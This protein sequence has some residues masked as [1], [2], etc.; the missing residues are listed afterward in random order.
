MAYTRM[1]TKGF[2]TIDPET[3]SGSADVQFSATQNDGRNQRTQAASLSATGVDAIAINIVQAGRPEFVS[4]EASKAAVKGGETVTITGESNSAS[5]TVSLGTGN[6]EVEVP[7]TITA[8]SV[9]TDNGA[10]IAGD[11]GATAKY[12]YTFQIVVPE[13]ETIEEK[14]KQIIITSAGG[15]TDT[16]VL[17]QAAGDPT[18]AIDPE[19]VNLTWEGT[20]VTA[21]ITSNT[22]WTI[23]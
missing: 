4:I 17:T 3:G 13:N 12:T 15:Q 19:T 8:N 14:T 1:I 11:P 16:C 2:A 6:L 18:L 9:A 23:A 20:A 5:L 21:H 22:N 10:E 7:A